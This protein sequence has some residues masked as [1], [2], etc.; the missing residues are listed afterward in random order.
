VYAQAHG[1]AGIACS[2]EQLNG[3]AYAVAALAPVFTHDKGSV[4]RVD[5][6]EML[7]GL[8][9]EGGRS[10]IFL[11]GRAA[12]ADLAVFAEAVEQVTRALSEQDPSPR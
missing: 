11:D 10:M 8:F 6:D 1:K 9:R 12:L 3:I 5:E 4:R 7:K 2:I